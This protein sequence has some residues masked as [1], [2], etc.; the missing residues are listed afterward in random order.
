MVDFDGVCVEDWETL[1]VE[2]PEG[3]RVPV[4]QV[5]RLGEGEVVEHMVMVEVRLPPPAKLLPVELKE[6]VGVMEAQPERVRVME[7]D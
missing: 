4:L 7:G 2:E 3:L 6:G 1:I 5:E